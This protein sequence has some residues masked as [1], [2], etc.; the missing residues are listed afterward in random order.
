LLI[1]E[2]HQG[3]EF[4]VNGA[5]LIQD[6][7]FI[8]AWATFSLCWTFRG[9][10]GTIFIFVETVAAEDQLFAIWLEWNRG[11]NIKTYL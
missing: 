5:Q 4:E 10:S 11:A 8:A 3:V 9:A 1:G 2:L 6:L 7:E